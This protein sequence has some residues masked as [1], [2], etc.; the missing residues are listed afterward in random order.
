VLSHPDREKTGGV[1]CER[2]GSY[3]RALSESGEG[4]WKG[5]VP[6]RGIYQLHGGIQAYLEAYGVERV[7]GSSSATS[8]TESGGED[9]ANPGSVIGENEDGDEGGSATTHHRAD[10]D[11]RPCLYRGKNFV[12]DPRRTDPV[13]GDGIAN[14]NRDSTAAAENGGRISH[15]GR[16]VMCSSPHDDYDNGHAPCE[17]R[18]ARCC[19]CRVLLL[20]CDGCR[21]RVRCWGEPQSDD[22]RKRDIF[23][24]DAGAKC[25]DD[26]NVAENVEV[27]RY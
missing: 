16:C 21:L 17:E 23:C 1:R 7:V 13:V 15:V 5:K 8:S 14:D 3:L 11:T 19:R 2:A 12:F 24:G 20:V 4:A 9:D 18:E 26:G 10:D 27:A 25:V 6:P 22:E